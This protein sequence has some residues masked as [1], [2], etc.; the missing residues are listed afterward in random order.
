MADEIFKEP[1]KLDAY[2]LRQVAETASGARG[3]DGDPYFLFEFDD[4]GGRRLKLWHG[5]PGQT[6][7]SGTVI[8]IDTRNMRPDRPPVTYASIASG[9]ESFR[10]DEKYD[11]VFWSEAAVEKFIFPYYASKSL[12]LA[13]Y[14]LEQL[15][16]AWYG[17]VPE[18]SADGRKDTERMIPF[19]IGHIP[20]SD[21]DVI[22]AEPGHDLDLLFMDE[23]GVSPKSLAVWIAERKAATPGT[24]DP[25]PRTPASPGGA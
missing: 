16:L 14:L 3:P 20:D 24:A 12:W 11:A 18:P 13:A 21:F 6:P 4:A 23:R 15:S 5:M 25:A 22:P 17:F 2:A 7:P 19:A 8:D 1:V 9:A 10:L